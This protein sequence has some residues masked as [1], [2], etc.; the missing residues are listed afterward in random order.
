MFALKSELG[1]GE[2]YGCIFIVIALVTIETPPVGSDATRH[3]LRPDEE[4]TINHVGRYEMSV[5]HLLGSRV[6]NEYYAVYEP[7]GNTKTFEIKTNG[8]VK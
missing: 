8:G 6:F 3:L 2:F 4:I 5:L 7:F 1:K